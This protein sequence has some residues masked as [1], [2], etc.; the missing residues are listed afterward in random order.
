MTFIDNRG[1]KEMDSNT[2]TKYINSN[3]WYILTSGQVINL[4]A[5]LPSVNKVYLLGS[6][7]ARKQ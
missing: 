3:V 4:W 6:I 7:F 2:E 5:D 1:N